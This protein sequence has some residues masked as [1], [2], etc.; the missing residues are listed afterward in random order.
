MKTRIRWRECFIICSFSFF[1]FFLFILELFSFLFKG[2]Y[3]N[4]AWFFCDY[5]WYFWMDS[6]NIIPHIVLLMDSCFLMCSELCSNNVCF[7]GCLILS[8]EL[9]HTS[10]IL[11]ARLSGATIRVFK[12]NS[13]YIFKILWSFKTPGHGVF[14]YPHSCSRSSICKYWGQSSSQFVMDSKLNLSIRLHRGIF[15]FKKSCAY[16]IHSG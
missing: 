4:N 13:E 12:H 14:S 7:Q 5:L 16:G 3:I 11:G 2:F 6:H 10:L 9:N 15:G 1:F 8:D